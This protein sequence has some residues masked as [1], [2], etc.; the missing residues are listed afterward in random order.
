M[1]RL[2][3]R[4]CDVAEEPDLCGGALDLINSA[5]SDSRLISLATIFIDQ[6]HSSRA[7]YHKMMEEIYYFI[8]GRGHVII[9]DQ[10]FHVEPG[11]AVFI[12]VGAVHQV[13]N[14]GSSRLKF[15]SADSPSYNPDDI[16]F[17]TQRTE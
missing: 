5:V 2:F 7:H 15:I 12:P 10:Q 13:I 3:V 14:R 6:N 17:P 11:S 8:E 9:D 16:H 4:E 1:P